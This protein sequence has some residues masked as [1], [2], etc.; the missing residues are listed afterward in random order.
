MKLFISVNATAMAAAL[1]TKKT[2][3]NMERKK[4]KQK[5]RKTNCQKG[6]VLAM[7]LTVK[8]VSERISDW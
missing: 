8:S 1:C 2:R 7:S 5:K 4:N 3:R 6:V